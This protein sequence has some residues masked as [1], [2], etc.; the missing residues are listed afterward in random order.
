MYSIE[1]ERVHNVNG[2]EVVTVTSFAKL[3]HRSEAT[4]RKMISVGNRYRTL[5]TEYVENKP[6]IP[7]NE[8][9]D[10]PFTM[11]GRGGDNVFQF[12]LK[13]TKLEIISAK[14]YCGLERVVMCDRQCENCASYVKFKRKETDE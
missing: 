1:G 7:V 11:Q 10:F 2:S 6:F 14:G 4:V 12:R 5:K 3:I 13:G 9:F 8:L